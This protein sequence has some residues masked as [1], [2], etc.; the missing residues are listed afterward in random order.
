MDSDISV[1]S[2]GE[3]PVDQPRDPNT[4]LPNVQLIYNQSTTHSVLGRPLKGRQV[5]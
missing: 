1:F 2:E 5:I 3:A 4:R